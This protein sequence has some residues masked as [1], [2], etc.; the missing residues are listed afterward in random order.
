MKNIFIIVVITIYC[1]PSF[2]QERGIFKDT[3]HRKSY[4]YLS[5]NKIISNNNYP[6]SFKDSISK[7]K[8]KLNNHDAEEILL[9]SLKSSDGRKILL[10]SS[11]QPAIRIPYEQKAV[12]NEMDFGNRIYVSYHW[13]TAHLFLP[14][15]IVKFI[16]IKKTKKNNYYL[17]FVRYSKPEYRHLYF[18]GNKVILRINDN[19]NEIDLIASLL[20]LCE[21]IKNSRAICY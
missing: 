16:R 14:Y 4:I 18:R 19:A 7:V 21:N 5:Q 8:N 12:D 17:E 2:S 10:S 9:N 13:E 6:A 20:F 3:L 11:K 1:L 15:E